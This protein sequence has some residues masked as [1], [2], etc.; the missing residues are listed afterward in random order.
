[1]MNAIRLFLIA[2]VLFT[3]SAIAVSA[4]SSPVSISV[5]VSCSSITVG[6]TS[7]YDRPVKAQVY[8]GSSGPTGWNLVDDI[9]DYVQA[10]ANGNASRTYPFTAQRPNTRI[11]FS[12]RVFDE[13]TNGLVAVSIGDRDCDGD[14]PPPTSTQTPG[15]GTGTAP[16]LAAC[17]TSGGITIQV[18]G[19]LSFSVSASQ[20]AQGIANANATHQNSAITTSSGI[21][22]TALTNNTI[23]I[24]ASN[25]YALAISATACGAVRPGTGAAPGVTC[26]NPPA[27][28][29]AVH[30][31]QAGENLFR[32]GIRYNIPYLRLASYN[33]IA[34]PTIIYVG[35]CIAIPPA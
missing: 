14:D 12:V 32:I 35:Q 23:Q 31:V 1:M 6:L 2:I 3:L 7:R 21:T 16:F 26:G 5:G 24:T 29:R 25:G 10:N 15:T 11:Y 18:I 19:G 13:I 27:D 4:Q 33:G 8:A 20:I 34:D 17:N 30:I 9:G 22:V 28:A